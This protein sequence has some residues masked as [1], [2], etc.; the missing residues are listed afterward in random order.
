LPEIDGRT[1]EEIFDE[2][3]ILQDPLNEDL[4][5][6]LYKD[7]VSLAM[8]AHK[9]DKRQVLV[10][11]RVHKNN[12]NGSPRSIISK[13]PIQGIIDVA[14]C[15]DDNEFHKPDP[16]VLDA[17]FKKSGLRPQDF[18][19]VGDQFVD[20]VLAKNLGINA[21]LVN[22]ND[23]PIPHLKQLGQDWEKFVTIVDSLNQIEIHPI[24]LKQ[25]N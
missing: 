18:T 5:K 13:P 21:I 3:L 22:R 9:N 16:R 1:V 8:R 25:N 4:E 19:V 12:G 11:N 20:A 7:A 14:V 17:I 6:H 10:S 24:P 23:H 15:A 2:F